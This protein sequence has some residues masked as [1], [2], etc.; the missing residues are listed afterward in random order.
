MLARLKR[1]LK[2][3]Y[4][5]LYHFRYFS[6]STPQ[7]K[8][9]ICFC[10]G[11]IPHGGWVDRL[12]GII[13]FYD[14]AKQ[15]DYEFYIY[16]TQPFQLNTYLESN[17][18]SWEIDKKAILYNPLTTKVIYVNN[19]FGFKVLDSLQQ[20]K[21]KTFFVYSNC[22]YL[23]MLYP[24]KSAQ[25]LSLLWH[26]RFHELFKKTNTLNQLISPY[27]NSSYISIHTRFTSLLGDF[28]DTTSGV[29]D[30]DSKQNLLESLRNEVERIS[31]ASKIPVYV[32]SD[33]QLF[34]DDVS[35]S[36]DVK[37]IKGQSVHMDDFNK[38]NNIKAQEKTLIDFFVLAGSDC[39]YFIRKGNMY[40]S[41]FSRYASIVGNC[42]FEVIDNI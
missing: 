29:L 18:V 32:M 17:T 38:D 11:T 21:K 23:Q 6:F 8:R 26:N 15:L 42:K 37:I 12:K 3:L 36:I 30:K 14:I 27:I 4:L 22:D 13:S 20:S 24:E 35:H 1:H 16:F 2:T 40:N 7:N 10:D 33:S 28:K 5:N 39:V 9:I 19:N 34:L 41:N 31:R 25:D